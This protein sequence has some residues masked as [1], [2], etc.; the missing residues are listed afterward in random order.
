[1]T[2]FYTHSLINKRGTKMPMSTCEG[3]EATEGS[4]APQI[5]GICLLTKTMIC[6]CA[7]ARSISKM[8][9]S[10][11][12]DLDFRILFS[13]TGSW[14]TSLHAVNDLYAKLQR[15]FLLLKNATVR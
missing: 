10:E 8:P 5:T 7:C 13:R 4:P 12:P 6:A 1:M 15:S 3:T 11:V 9:V 14:H 2:D